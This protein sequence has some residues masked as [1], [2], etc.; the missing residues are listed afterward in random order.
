MAA[1]YNVFIS[2]SGERSRMVAAAFRGWLP[3]VIQASKP[4]MSEIDIDKGTR[5]FDEIAK[6]L[7]GTKLGVICLTPEN[8]ASLWVAFEAGALSK[9]VD[10]KTRVFTYLVGGIAP[11][12]ITGPLSLFQAT[13]AEQED[14]RK[15]LHSLN[16]ALGNTL[17]E[18]SLNELFTAMWPRMAE[19][20]ER[21]RHAQPEIPQK[22]DVDD[23]VAET[24]ELVRGLSRQ[25]E[26]TALSAALMK[27]LGVLRQY[28][29][30]WPGPRG[31]YFATAPIGSPGVPGPARSLRDLANLGLSGTTGRSE[32]TFVSQGLLSRE[33]LGKVPAEDDKP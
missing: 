24:L 1:D 9:T 25:L 31:S 6:A 7:E 13:T 5:S 28:I 27:E 30:N 32:S 23:M 12:E 4:W 16:R 26:G 29:D 18:A 15:M 22:R 20:L 11:H 17:P 19:V 33:E 10:D 21:V 8:R 14:T 2:W 3:M